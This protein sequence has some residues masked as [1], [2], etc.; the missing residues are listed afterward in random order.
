MILCSYKGRRV[1]KLVLIAIRAGSV[2]GTHCWTT[3][4]VTDCGMQNSKGENS[5]IVIIY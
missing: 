3:I 4:Q 2:V 1:V 5:V